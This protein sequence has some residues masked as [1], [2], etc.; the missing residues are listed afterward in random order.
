MPKKPAKTIAPTQETVGENYLFSQ[1]TAIIEKRKNQAAAPVSSEATIIFWEIG[2][3]INT[4]LLGDSR[5][6]YGKQIFPTLS[7]KL[8]RSDYV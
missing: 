8:P 5:A 3:F 7:G 1:I 2:H 4:T 6:E